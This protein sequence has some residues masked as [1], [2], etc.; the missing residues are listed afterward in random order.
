[1]DTLNNSIIEGI[2]HALLVLDESLMIVKCNRQFQDVFQLAPDVGPGSHLSKALPESRL[3]AM[4]KQ[5]R[6]SN[7]PMHEMEF[8]CHIGAGEERHFL[9]AVS[10]IKLSASE[11]GA[12]VTFDEITEWKR[13][14]SQVMEASRLVSVG[15]MAA[16]IAHEINNP[17]AAVMGFS[18]LVLRRDVDESVRKDLDK[19][20]A[21][22][23]RASKIIANLQS[24]A[25]RYK[26]RKEYVS[27]ADIVQK[28]LDFRS[29][30]LQV[31]NI[32][33]ITRFDPEVPYVFGD[34]HQLEQ[35]FLNIVTNA[36]QFMASAHGEGTL[37]VT[38][39]S[40][41]EKIL[42]SFSDD[43]PGIQ[44]D[45]LPK[46][47]DPFFTTKDVGSGTG[48]GLSICYG[49]VHEHD[50]TI[51]VESTYGEGATVVIELPM[52][53]T[54]SP[55]L[56][57]QE[58][59]IATLP[60]EKM[61]ILVVDDEPLIAECLSRT[62]GDEGH[63]VELAKTGNELIE[64]R[65][66]TRYDIIILDVK[67]PG[68]DGMELFDYI[69]QLSGDV[70][71]RVMFITGDISNPATRE[72]I[73]STGNPMIAKPFTLDGLVSAVRKFAMKQSRKSVV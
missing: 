45:D 69:K 68:I 24:F 32:E 64:N 12:L 66:L 34:E 42:I 11:D 59:P 50:G 10:I 16:G 46:I 65:D 33:V 18:Q 26:P 49:M 61:R 72:F 58:S 17:L 1:M 13:R 60:P 56:A 40:A 53:E 44:K 29:Y 52:P 43:G 70:S 6:A 55:H 51:T 31:H 30:E 14:Q 73:T 15:E 4:I 38:I 5:C 19:I 8:S 27:V 48:L 3:E 2:N 21:E 41:D 9:V 35:V 28:I 23:K 57:D 47:F 20:L 71:S 36:E 22:A 62:L 25:R 67:M 39:E 54:P 7:K 63:L 37:I